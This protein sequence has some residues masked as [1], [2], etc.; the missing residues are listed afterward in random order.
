MWM[1]MSVMLVMF[2]RP[3]ELF[4]SSGQY[5]VHCL[6][7][8]CRRQDIGLGWA[9]FLCPATKL[10]RVLF[11]VADIQSPDTYSRPPFEF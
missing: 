9:A 5:L 8:V 6:Q 10:I 11:V 1:M 3:S 7:I 4:K 2:Q